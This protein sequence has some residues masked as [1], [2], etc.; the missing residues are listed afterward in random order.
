[1]QQSFKTWR[2]LQSIENSLKLD[3]DQNTIMVLQEVMQT[4]EC[5]EFYSYHA[6]ASLCEKLAT[7]LVRYNSLNQPKNIKTRIIADCIFQLPFLKIKDLQEPP[8]RLP[9]AYGVGRNVFATDATAVQVGRAC[10]T[11]KTQKGVPRSPFITH[12]ELL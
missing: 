1:M 12:Q 4:I 3:I 6:V 11:F 5:R 9:T 10:S 2:A 8:Y 7:F